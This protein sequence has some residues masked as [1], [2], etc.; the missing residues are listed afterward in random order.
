MSA[1]PRMKGKN[2][3]KD[4]TTKETP[5]RAAYLKAPPVS[6]TYLEHFERCHRLIVGEY[7]AKATRRTAQPCAMA[8]PI[9]HRKARIGAASSRPRGV[10]ARRRCEPNLLAAMVP[11]ARPTYG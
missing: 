7:A 9:V 8:T 11:T 5:K 3:E 4:K 10:A 1:E 6:A 2:Y